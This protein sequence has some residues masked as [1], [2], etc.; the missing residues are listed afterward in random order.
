[1]SHGSGAKKQ[2]HA[3]EKAIELLGGQDGEPTAEDPSGERAGLRT[4]LEQLLEDWHAY[5][6]ENNP[7]PPE[8]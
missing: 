7:P 2:S 3:L 5:A 1:M 8:K 4:R 6:V